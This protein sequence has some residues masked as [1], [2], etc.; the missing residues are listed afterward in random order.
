[1]KNYKYIGLLLL[2]FSVASCDVNNE[3]D[4]ITDPVQA[5]VA[6]NTNGLD[7]SS[8]IAVGASLTAGFTD[9]ALFKAGQENSYPN[10][11][12]KKF[13]VGAT[14]TQPLMEDNIGGMLFGGSAVI[15][16]P[17][18]IFDGAGPV[19][20]DAIPTTEGTT[21]LTGGF[22]NYGI[23]GAKSFHIVADGLGNLDG[24]PLGQANPYY[25]RMAT[26]ATA[27]VL[28]DAMA[29]SPTF[30]TLSEIGGNDV[31]TYATSGGVGVDQSP[32]TTNPNGNLDPRTY[33]GN[34]ITNP[35]V[36]DQV[37]RA[38]LT[39]LTSGE[40]KG[41]I[42]TV[43]EITLLPFF[44]TVPNNALELP[45]ATAASLTGFFQAVAGIFTQGAIAQGASAEDAQALGAQY[46]ITFTEGNNR[47]IIDV[48]VSPT[49]PLGFRQM[50]E[51]ELLVLTIDQ[52]ALKE[53]YGSVL[54]T[55]EVLEVLGKLQEGIDITPTEGQMVLGAVNG[56]DDKD[57][58]DT[59]ELLSIKT[60][61]EAYNATIADVASSN[62]NVAVIDLNA[63]LREAASGIQFDRYTMTTSLV[64]GGLVSLDGIHL[65]ARGYALM[66]NRILGAID[67]K[68]G[69]N[70]TTATNGLAKAD[71]Y[72]TNYTPT[73]Q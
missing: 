19:R 72:P 35:L 73:L 68:F 32:T 4:K 10:I 18:L 51:N 62:E 39:I 40:A 52:S 34:D 13:G 41:V 8:Y 57:A 69:S 43:P 38:M 49:N 53:G 26:S 66:A 44:T 67:A 28:A 11:L 31:L 58:L 7:F 60:A 71:D 21:V 65:T 14:F 9:G 48:P 61:I 54:L 56:L 46:A 55:P 20:L 29:Q 6:L 30:F 33:G 5:E 59:D 47:W 25:A 64:T 37:F 36:F 27:N 17:R 22:N 2:S 42:A 70:F 15:Q 3:L 1:M 45:T 50:T 23:P 16:D 63:I 24:V 12:A